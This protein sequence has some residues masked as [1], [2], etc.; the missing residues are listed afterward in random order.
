MLTRFKGDNGV[1]DLSFNYNN[2]D[3]NL[4]VAMEIRHK[5]GHKKHHCLY[6]GLVLSKIPRHLERC[7]KDEEDVKTALECPKKSK[8]RAN[9]WQKITR[10]GDFEIN[11]EAMKENLD[12]KP[13]SVRKSKKNEKVDSLPCE[14]CYGFFNARKLTEHT[15]VCFLQKHDA[16][17]KSCVKSSRVMLATSITDG[18]FGK[19]HQQI[20]SRMKRDDLHLIVRN[21]DMLLTL[22][23][24]EMEKKDKF[25]FQDICY[26][27]RVVGK[28]LI[29]Y[30]K[31]SNNEN[32]RSIDLVT[33]QN[34]DTVVSAM[35]QMSGYK[36]SRDITNPHLVLKIG[37]SL[38]TL[39]LIA[40]MHYLK[41][42]AMDMVEKMRCLMELYETDY[43]IFSNNARAVYEKRQGNAPEELPDEC[44]VKEVRDFCVSE[45]CRLS[46]NNELTVEEH[47]SLSKFV[48]VRLLTFNARRGGEPAKL[49][50][51]DWKN[52]EKDVW[53]RKSD[54]EQLT[55]PVEMA[56]AKRLKLCYVEGKR[57]VAGINCF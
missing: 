11:I 6:C 31:L 26:T 53:K 34:Y 35:K 2:G 1:L 51:E 21:D 42:S 23:S 41:I 17:A 49:T 16:K 52:V 27:L 8:E 25:R 40:K 33:P 37:Y 36:G 39:A 5:H 44:D 32:A 57:K 45:I 28:L 9:I 3:D 14:F 20:L 4:F 46:E 19:V 22:A 12:V 47:R 24:V 43:A 30:K 38:R 7:H 29:Q 55:D 50:L 54:M 15:K 10:L 56:L 18:K 13:C 48:Y